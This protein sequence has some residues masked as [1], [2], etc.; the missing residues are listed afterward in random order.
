MSRAARNHAAAI[1]SRLH[2]R[3][4]DRAG[5]LYGALGISHL[6]S[7]PILT[8]RAG[9]M[10]GY[11]VTDPTQV[12]PE[13]GGEAGLRGAGRG[14]ARRRAWPDR[15]YRAEPYG[16]GRDGEPLVGAMC[17]GTAG[18]AAMRHFFDIDWDD[19]T[20]ARCSHHSSANRTA[21]HCAIGTI[22][23]VRDR[24]EPV[25]RYFDNAVPDPPEDHAQIAA[26][27]P[28]AFDPATRGGQGAPASAAGAPALPARLVA[29]RRRRDQL[30][31]LL[32][33]QRPG[34]RCASRTRRC[35]RRRM[36]RCSGCIAKG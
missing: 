13:L 10:H 23:L 27:P 12:N 20:E 32:R 1:A 29:Q 14:T 33:H 5:A 31:T 8:A 16:G 36:P 26:A 22:T 2:L 6:Y 18:R 19:R 28:D 34:R 4:C 21:R 35:S 25:I 30:A 17:C 9:S 24:D 11:D 15:R 3:R 7:S